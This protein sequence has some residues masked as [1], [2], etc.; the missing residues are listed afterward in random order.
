VISTQDPVITSESITSRQTLREQISTLIHNKDKSLLNTTKL[1]ISNTA[2]PDKQDIIDSINEAIESIDLDPNLRATEEVLKSDLQVAHNKIIDLESKVTD[3]ESNMQAIT[4]SND[5]LTNTISRLELENDSLRSMVTDYMEQLSHY[6]DDPN[7]IQSNIVVNDP[8][9]ESLLNDIMSCNKSIE[10]SVKSDNKLLL[11]KLNSLTTLVESIANIED[12][13][14]ENTK[15][16]SRISE[17][18]TD[19]N[20]SKAVIAESKKSNSALIVKYDNVIKD[21]FS[22]RCNQLGL[23]EKLELRKFNN[24]LHEYDLSD[25]NDALTESYRGGTKLPEKLSESLSDN[26]SRPLRSII[27]ENMNKQPMDNDDDDISVLSGLV[28]SVRS[29]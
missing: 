3:L 13:M 21:Y 15:L 4:S 29:N 12:I 2:I 8:M 27:V 26:G 1:L 5:D 28:K 14:S 20:K 10:E 17:L 22:L 9:K 23:N 18:Q 11:S 24:S 16:N 7:T 19:L 6:Y 25:I